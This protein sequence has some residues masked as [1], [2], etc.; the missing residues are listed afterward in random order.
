MCHRSSRITCWKTVCRY[1]QVTYNGIEKF[2][3]K[4]LAE[5]SLHFVSLDVSQKFPHHF[6]EESLPLLS[7]DIQWHR[8]ILNERFGWNFISF[9]KPG[10]VTEVPASLP[11]RKFAVTFKW[12]PGHRKILNKRFGW[13]FILFCK[14]RCVTEEPASLPGRKFAVTFKWHKVAYK[15]SQWKIWL[16]FHFIL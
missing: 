9:C 1:F 2:S 15:N 3:I 7:S 8:K 6:L 13:N 4:E 14:R 11:G 16:K 5:I 12:H 10:C